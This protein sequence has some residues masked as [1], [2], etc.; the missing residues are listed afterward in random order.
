MN[1]RMFLRSALIGSSLLAAMSAEAT[2]S[3]TFN[4]TATVLQTCSVS[5]SDLAFGGINVVQN[6]ETDATT[7][8]ALTCGS[9]VNY[10][11]GLDAG[12]GSGSTTTTRLMTNTGGSGTLA[13][14][15]FQD[16]GHSTNWGNNP[17]IDTDPSTGTGSQ[18]SLTVYGVVPAGQQSTPYGTYGDTITVNVYY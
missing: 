14:E 15:L 16:S 7:T 4:V 9:G 10:S 2:G 1:N 12:Q 11:V 8:I 3:A 18:Q 5:A 6:T 17:G 13:Y